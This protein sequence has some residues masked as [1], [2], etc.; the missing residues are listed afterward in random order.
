MDR[1][2]DYQQGT[3]A[4]KRT[5]LPLPTMHSRSQASL[6]LAM[7]LEATTAKRIA[8]MR[9]V[10]AWLERSR[11][12]AALPPDFLRLEPT[13]VV[14][15]VLASGST[16]R[17]RITRLAVGADFSLRLEGVAETAAV[18]V[19][20][21]LADGGQGRLPQLVTVEAATRLILLDL[22][23]LRD[24]DD[25]AGAGSRLVYLMAGYGGPGWPGAALYRSSDGSAWSQAGRALGEA[26][27]GATVNGL[28]SPVSP[29]S[30]DEA[31]ALVVF[32]TTGGEWL[33]SVTQAAMLDGAN[34]ALVLKANGEPEVIQFRDVT[35]NPDGSF[36]LTGLLRGRP[37]T[38]V[39]VDG[40]Q[41]GELFVLLDPD[42]I[43]TLA[44]P[45]GEL[46]LAR[47]W[48]AVGFGSLF[49][50]A[51]TVV[52]AHAGRD[53]M[54]LAPVHV[55]ATLT[56]NPADI[57]LSWVR[58]TRIGGEL[59]DGTGAV[60]LGEASEAYAVDIRDGPSGAVLRTLA[61]T[62]PSAVYANADI[63][64]DLGAVPASLTVAVH[65]L[66][67]VAGRGFARIVTLPIS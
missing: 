32:M 54:P 50:D 24:V 53:L 23:H 3:Q 61:S 46:G 12:E 43:E 2:A 27:W 1:D 63:L 19:S 31:N 29:F 37:G 49:E 55:T 65:Q 7:A 48:R 17:T 10:S 30:T 67:A 57:T 38:D 6:E 15:V 18:H 26:A 41:S 64:A 58:R 36:T 45:L 4:A 59:R 35:L 28:G 25:T 5:S 44:V 34:A 22:P 16:F 66:S 21:V 47:S 13:D 52:Q 60:P 42:D 33:E 9:L 39:F 56:G 11:Y 62:S 51:E 14:D 8:E 40:H 20:T